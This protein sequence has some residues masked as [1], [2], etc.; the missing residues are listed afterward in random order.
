ML[1]CKRIICGDLK[2]G[3]LKADGSLNGELCA[4]R[5]VGKVVISTSLDG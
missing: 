1:S 5:A 4:L 2:T 3:K